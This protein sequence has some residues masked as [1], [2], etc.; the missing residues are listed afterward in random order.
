MTLSRDALY[1]AAGVAGLAAAAFGA[2]GTPRLDVL[3]IGA[4]ATV[5]GRPISR[6]AADRAVQALSNDKRNAVTD[7]DQEAALE[8]LIEEELLVQRGVALGLAETDLNA[9]KAIVQSVLQ[10]AIAERT[11]DEPSEAS[12]RTFYAD[13]AGMF[14]PAA[15]LRGS[16]VFVKRDTTSATR[17]AAARTALGAGRSATN[18]GDEQALVLPTAMLS[19]TELRTY[20]GA[21]LAASASQAKAGDII[22]TEAPDGW[23]L[24]RIDAKAAPAMG[25]YEDVATEVRAEWDRRADETAVRAYIERLKRRARITRAA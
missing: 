18:L 13:N 9:R 15:R 12:L 16:L 8:R 2:I 6:E 3:G 7:A 24:L 19:P 22:V 25:R 21:A 5:D 4:V 1:L 11:G 10:L 17:V 20:L 23:R 14:A